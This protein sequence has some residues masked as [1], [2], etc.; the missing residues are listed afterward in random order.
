MG[1]DL[2]SVVVLTIIAIC[3]SV[4]SF[5]S[6]PNADAKKDVQKV[7]IVSIGGTSVWKTLPV[8]VI[9]GKSGRP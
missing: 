5:N 9:G 8:K 1:N 4:L 2:Y 6:I 7:D 3:L